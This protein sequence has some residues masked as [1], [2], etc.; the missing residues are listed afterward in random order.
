MVQ[1]KIK[2]IHISPL[3]L[4]KTRNAKYNANVFSYSFGSD[5]DKAIPLQIACQTNGLWKQISDYGD[6]RSQM[7]EYYGV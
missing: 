3:N 1:S 2:S 7:A 6:L 5:A 4:I